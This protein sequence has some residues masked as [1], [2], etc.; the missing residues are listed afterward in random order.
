MFYFLIGLSMGLAVHVI[1]KSNLIFKIHMSA[2]YGE[3]IEIEGNDY[4][5]VFSN[6]YEKMKSNYDEQLKER[7]Q[8][9]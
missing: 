8:K 6:R 7:N 2:R 9:K 1:R 4:N 5:I 3:S